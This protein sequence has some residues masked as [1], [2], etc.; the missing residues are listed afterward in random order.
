[1]VYI[2]ILAASDP[3]TTNSASC[4]LRLDVSSVGHAAMFFAI[5]RGILRR[6]TNVYLAN[7][8]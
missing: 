4:A 7:T 3:A 5:I 2:T 1:M 8:M 6:L